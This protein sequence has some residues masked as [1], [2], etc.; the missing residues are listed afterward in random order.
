VREFSDLARRFPGTSHAERAAFQAAIIMFV[1]GEDSA[2]AT[3]FDRVLELRP[4]GA[5]AT[6]SIYWSGRA[7]EAAGDSAR[8]R[9]RW[10]SLLARFPQSY[11]AFRQRPAWGAGV[12]A[13]PD[14]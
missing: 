6:A 8:A 10:R 5:E 1:N 14:R 11:Y 4:G 12:V 7:W 3:G 2:A 9:E 13:G